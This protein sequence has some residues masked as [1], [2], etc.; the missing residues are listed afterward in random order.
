M[1]LRGPKALTTPKGTAVY[2]W[3]NTPSTKFNKEG[4]YSTKLR[5]KAS[6]PFIT[7]MDALFDQLYKSYLEES[8]LKK[9]K[10]ADRP[11]KVE[12]DKKTGEDLDTVL[13]SFKRKA[14]RGP[15]EARTPAGPPLLVD[16]HG[17]PVTQAVG[18]GSTIQVGFAVNPYFTASLGF[19]LTLKLDAVMVH[20]L[21]GYTAKA[22]DYD[23]DTADED[24]TSDTE[25]AVAS[26]P[27]FN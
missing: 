13:L 1:K 3:V 20:E 24:E 10:Q 2:C 26:N 5:L 14:L 9:C 23:F 19:G 7:K 16:N 6:D 8:G 18:S 15:L 12:T 22:E 11:W 17:K 4:V 21:V 25:P 27:D